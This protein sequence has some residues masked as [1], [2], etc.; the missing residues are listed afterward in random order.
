MNAPFKLP[1]PKQGLLVTIVGAESTGKT[2]LALELVEQLKAK[3]HHATM[4]PE[5]L[6]EFC[7][8][9]GRTPHEHEQLGLAQAQTQRIQAARA[10]HDIV[11][12][13]TS[14]LMISVYSEFI[15]GDVSL[16]AMALEAHAQSDLTLLT[17]VDLPWVADGFVRDGEHVRAPVDALIRS[18]LIEAGLSHSVIGGT[19]A[20]R[21][22]AALSVVEHALHVAELQRRGQPRKPWRWICEKCDDGDCEQHGP[23]AA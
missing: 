15:F 1:K 23:V 8:R 10:E 16:H 20:Q 5:V 9:E 12:A 19:G 2:T 4:V 3:G 14:A 17:A 18:K 21:G 7:D 22:A 11:V 13:D 6:R